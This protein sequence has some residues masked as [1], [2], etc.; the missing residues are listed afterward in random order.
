MM[1][2]LLPLPTRQTAADRIWNSTFAIQPTA[3]GYAKESRRVGLYRSPL[4]DDGVAWIRGEF[5]GYFEDVQGQAI[6]LAPHHEEFWK[7][8]WSLRP[9]IRQP[10]FI[11]IWPRS[12]GKS[13]SSELACVSIAYWGLRRYGLYCCSTQSQAD[14]HVQTIGTLLGKLGVERAISQYGY[15]MGW[16]INRLRTADGFVLDALGLDKAIRGVKIEEMRPDLMIFDDLDDTLDTP[17][18][19]DKKIKALTRKIIPG[20]SPSLSIV[21]VQ[22]IPNADGIFAQLADGRGDFLLNRH[23]SGPHPALV[24]FECQIIEQDDGPNRYRIT[25]GTPTW[26][27]LSIA[28][29]EGLLNDIGLAAFEVECQ[30]QTDRLHGDMFQRDWF[31]IVNDFPHGMRLIRFWDLASTEEK[32]GKNPDYTAGALVGEKNGQYWILDMKRDRLSPLKVETL[33]QD[34][35]E[36]DGIRV[37]IR[38]EQEPGASGKHVISHFQRNV[39]AGFTVS[40]FHSTGSKTEYARILSSAAEAGNVFLVRGAWN[41]AFITEAERFPIGDHD[42][43]VDAAS[44]A[45][46]LMR[47]PKLAMPYDVSGSSNWNT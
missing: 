2:A 46:S 11:A 22:N 40:G 12:G 23:I 13:T 14:D 34:T 1:S 44:K 41:D 27:G 32:P 9:G 45:V 20:G 16:R 28:S 47:K 37:Q 39:L 42:D 24:D 21:G 25:K 10:S 3:K 5:P 29:C 30:H 18:T 33:I 19:I 4:P 26:P 7:W 36:A 8:V 15:S 6:P 31:H 43:Q 35:A 38:I 17:G